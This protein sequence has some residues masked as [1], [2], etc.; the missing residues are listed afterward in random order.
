VDNRV[1][2]RG[3]REVKVS[4][5]AQGTDIDFDMPNDFSF[6]LPYLPYYVKETLEIGGQAYVS[7]SSNGTVSGI[8]IYDGIEKTGSIFTRSREV[9]DHFYQLKPFDSLFAELKTEHDCETYD[10][11]NVDVGKLSFAHSFTYEISIADETQLEPLEQFMV[12]TH[13]GMNRKWVG[14]ALKDGEKCFV[15]RLEN[16]IAGLGWVSIVEGI[17][18]LHS[19]FVR[20]QFRRIGIGRDIL[21]ARL[22]WLKARR[23]RSAFSEISRENPSSSRIAVGGRMSVSGQVYQYFK[24]DLKKKT[25][26]LRW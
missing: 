16:E 25:R 21:Y 14:V 6:F 2:A 26:T 19:L 20:P 1:G 7:R 12:S 8:F 9:F 10:I 23:A 11:Y 15:A 17:G 18:R 13:Q 3:S 24:K 22:F 4:E 5:L